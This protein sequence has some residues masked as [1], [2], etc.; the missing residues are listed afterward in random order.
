MS[1]IVDYYDALYD[2][3][4]G[5]SDLN[6]SAKAAKVS[7]QVHQQEETLMK[8]VLPALQDKGFKI[9]GHEQADRSL[10]APTIAF[11]SPKQ[12]S[13]T[14][15]QTLQAQGIACSH[16]HFYGYRIVRALGLEPEDGI[17]RLS[18]LHYNTTEESEQIVEALRK[19]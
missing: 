4:F 1:G 8:A 2:H 9:V 12:A 15:T 16:G 3:H 5:T 6:S 11:Y 13:A 19:L 17:V 7:E 18:L 10:R 14:I